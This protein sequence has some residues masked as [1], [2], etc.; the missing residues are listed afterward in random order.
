MIDPESALEKIGDPAQIRGVA[1][2]IGGVLLS[3]AYGGIASRRTT[4]HPGGW[5]PH[6]EERLG[7]ERATS[8]VACGT[9]LS[10]NVRQQER[11]LSISTGDGRTGPGPVQPRALR[12]LGGLLGHQSPGLAGGCGRARVAPTLQGRRNSQ[13]W[14]KRAGGGVSQ[15]RTGR[16]CGLHGH[17]GE[18]GCREAGSEVST[19]C[20][21]RRWLK[22]RNTCC[23]SMTSKRTSRLRATWGSGP[24]KPDRRQSS[25]SC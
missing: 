23:S 13:W 22:L 16:P 14:S 3:W 25:F 6:G 8:Y 12:A 2:D 17:S 5:M 21:C 19:T 11:F 15:V 1:L 24:S 9:H 18:V 4:G 7:L 20:C 10:T